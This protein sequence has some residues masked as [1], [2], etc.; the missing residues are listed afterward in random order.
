MIKINNKQYNNCHT[1]ITWGNFNVS[2]E[3]GRK[4][5]GEAPFITFHIENG[6]SIGLEFTFLRVMFLNTKISIE[7]N[8]KEYI[9][10]IIFENDEGWHSLILEKYD[11][12]ITRINQKTFHINFHVEESKINIFINE[13]IDLF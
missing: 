8:I 7:T 6:M 3:N 9:S 1:E 2:N 5:T 11:C 10:D 13:N 12:N 4:R